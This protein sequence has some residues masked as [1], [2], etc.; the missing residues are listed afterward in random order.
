MRPFPRIF[1]EFIEEDKGKK[2]IVGVFKSPI[3]VNTDVNPLQMIFN[4]KKAFVGK[5]Y[6]RIN[7]LLPLPFSLV[8]GSTL[9]GKS[10]LPKPTLKEFFLR[11]LKQF[12]IYIWTSILFAKMNVYLR[13]I[14]RETGIE[15]DLQRIMG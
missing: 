6:F 10:V 7:H 15:I 2:L 12:T 14:T 1:H 5:E 9:L 3:P 4:L 11:R 13:K 8:W